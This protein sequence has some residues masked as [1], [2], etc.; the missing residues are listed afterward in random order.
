MQLRHRQKGLGWFGLLFVFAVIGFTAIV[1]A[2]CFPIYMNQM[3][4]VSAL[5]KVSA[6]PDLGASEGG[7]SIR[8][9][10]QRYWDIDDITR[11]EPKDIKIKRSDRGR[12]MVYD[13]EA[14]ERLFYNIYIVIHF[15]DEIPLSNRSS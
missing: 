13:Y 3:K 15:K 14:K 2:K 7:E 11:I 9:T 8:K 1:A 12:F 4:L 5:N 10:L 6:E